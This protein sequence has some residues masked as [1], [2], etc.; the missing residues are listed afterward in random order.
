VVRRLGELVAAA[1]LEADLPRLARRHVLPQLESRTLDSPM[2]HPA[3][4]DLE[5]LEERTGVTP[6][7]VPIRESDARLAAFLM[8]PI[9]HTRV[10]ELKRMLAADPSFTSK[11]LLLALGRLERRPFWARWMG[12]TDEREQ[13]AALLDLMR[14]RPDDEVL[15][16]VRPYLRHRDPE[17]A[18]LARQIVEG[19]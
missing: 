15:T 14:A 13:L 3:W 12:G 4:R 10:A 17:L 19:R 5:F 9:W 6:V 1:R 11:P 7:S 2:R 8:Q 16:R 18:M